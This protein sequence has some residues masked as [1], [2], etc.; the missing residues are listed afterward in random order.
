[1]PTA[2]APDFGPLLRQY[3]QAAGLTQEALAERA[4]LSARGIQNLER[5]VSRVPRPDT[6]ELLATALGLAARDRAA[7]LGAALPPPRPPSSSD[8]HA[9][10]AVGGLTPLVGRQVELA[11]LSGFLAG[12]GERGRG[13]PL[14]LLAGEPGIGKTRL[15]QAGVRQAIAQGW[16]VLVGGCHRRG[17]Q[18]PFAPLLDA[19]ALHLHAERPAARR[20]ALAGCAWLVRL[21][22]ELAP[23]LEPLPAGI[24]A[25]EQERR[26]VFAAVARLLANVARGAAAPAGTLLVLDDLQ[27]AGADALDLLATLVRG[28]PTTLRIVGA[29][30]DTE[31]RAADPLGLLLADLAQ[32]RLARQHQLGPLAPAEAAALLAH[33]L[34]DGAG[35][36]PSQAEGVLRRAGGTPFF[37]VSY[38]EALHQGS[39]QGVPW[40]LTA[41]VRQRLALLPAAGQEILGAAAVAGRSVSRALLVAIA[42]QPLHEVLLGLEAA[43][44]A[45]L[46]L[47]DGEDG[48]AFAHDVIRE[49]LEADLGA[50]RRA[51]LHL[52]VAEALERAPSDVPPERL[53]YHYTG[54]GAPDKALVSLERAG[55]HAWGQRAHGAAEAYYRQALERMDGL[56]RAHD[57][58]RVREKLGEVLHGAGRYDAALAVLEQAAKTYGTVGDPEGLVRVTA[59]M[60]WAHSLRGT[61]RTGIALITALLERLGRDA[62][63]PPP[64]APLYEALCWL[65]FTDGRYDAAL[66]AGERAAALARAHG[67]ERTLAFAAAHRI[68]ILQ[69]LGRLAEALLVGR[70]A[71][72]LAERVGDLTCLVGLHCD[73]AYIHALQGALAASRRSLD[74][75]LALAEQAG[76]PGRLAY[77]LAMRSWLAVLGGDRTGAHTDLG[78]AASVSSQAD[79]SWYSP[80]PLIFGACLSLSET[81]LV[82]AA[83]ALGDALALAE[84]SGD[85]QARRWAAATLAEI[86]ILEVRPAAAIARLLPLLDRPGLQECDVTA[87]LPVLAWAQLALGQ[88]DEAAANVEQALRRARPEGMRLALVEALRVRAL[89]ALLREQWDTA[90]GSLAEGLALAREMPSPYLEARMLQV[91]A[92]L[93]ALGGAPEA[94]PAGG[95]A[96]LAV[97]RI[98]TA[99][100]SRHAP[101]HAAA[102][103]VPEPMH[104]V[105]VRAGPERPTAGTRGAGV[106][107]T[108]GAVPAAP[109]PRRG[110]PEERTA[111]VLGYLHTFGPIAPGLYAATMGMDRRT[112]LRD[113]Q[114][115]VA[116]GLIV[117]QGTTKDRRYRLRSDQA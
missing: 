102:P 95:D 93:R 33:L 37:L 21:L 54:G 97:A 66:A 86:E 75:A 53:A 107:M 47:E 99:P 32:A 56:G 55:D 29:Y 6:A 18:E 30:R 57:A 87:L 12:P 62:A 115:L 4:C 100:R 103:R 38:A 46:L 106:L 51:V 110:P 98:P 20:A 113:L 50:A 9:P 70:E 14:L 24:L 2:P 28:A 10:L 69:T 7:L 114:A 108:Q 34:A 65:L 109:A 52:R 58:L 117:A 84:A 82:P 59:A 35:G 111:W 49:V 41:G 83:A 19:L 78:R 43:C 67:D 17:G 68:N 15:L 91:A 94:A 96:G 40:D 3:R 36:E 44:R 16:R 39:T 31:V 92:R 79:R 8:H 27:W 23:A 73:L 5:G 42:E 116:R 48:Y 1:M 85:L 89:I 61:I 101:E 104:A 77:T 90:A 26:L 71:L 76:S 80:Y 112:A 63:S 11:L 45:R 64:L 74:R 25:P 88:V 13:V 81:D 22:P 105:A 72:P 60:G